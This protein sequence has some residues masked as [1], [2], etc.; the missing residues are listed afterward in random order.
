MI[1]HRTFALIVE[2][3]RC[4]LLQRL[5]GI[6]R[7]IT[8]HPLLVHFESTIPVVSATRIFIS[9]SPSAFILSSLTRTPPN[10]GAIT[11][12]HSLVS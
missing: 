7:E 5:D 9:T 4:L 10:C 8:V 12:L 1:P 2:K 11:L 3:V 6:I